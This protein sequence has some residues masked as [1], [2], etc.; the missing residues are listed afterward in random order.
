[1]KSAFFSKES[2]NHF[3]RSYV[4]LVIA[5]FFLLSGFIRP[6]NL[7]SQTTSLSFTNIP[8]NYP[9]IISPGRG[10]EQW[11]NGYGSINYPSQDLAQQ[12]LDAY[13]R[14]TWNRLE[15]SAQGSYDW[16]YFD[17]LVKEVINK[18]Q[19]LSFGIMTCYPDEG[20][21]PGMVT[22]DN[23]NSAYPEYLHQ[24]MQSEPDKDWKTTGSGPTDGYGSWVPNWNSQYYL[25]RLRALHEALYAHI[26]SSSYTATAGP[27]KGK[28]IAYSD[29]IF[30]ID[31]RGYGS[32]GE[33][34]SAGIINVMTSYPAGRRPT[35]ATLKTIIDHHV[36]VF[37][38][39]PLS[40][41]ISAFD[42]E[43]LSNTDNPKEVAAY[44]L[45][46]TNNWGKLGWRRD[47]W[48]AIDSYIDGYLKDNTLSYG[49]SGPFNAIINERWKYAPVT[50]EPPSWLASLNGACAYDDLE[51]QIREYHA[52]SFGNGNYG[53][54]D[55]ADCA[56]ENIRAAFKAAGYRIILEGG[57][58]SSTIKTGTAFALTLNWKNIGIA[59]TYEKWDVVFELK[60]SSDVSVWSGISQF[61][62][63][64]KM[65]IPALLP[66]SAAAPAVDNFTLPVNIPAG[67]YN[68][69]IIIKDPAGYRVP[70]PLAITGR[71]PD[72]SYTLKNIVVDSNTTTPTVPPTPPPAPSPLKDATLIG[73]IGL[74][75]RPA[76]PDSKWQ[77][78]LQVDL[79][80]DS[81]SSTLVNTYTVTTDSTGQFIID[82]I[83]P[84]KYNIAV[85]NSHTLKRN[86][87]DSLVTGDNRIFFGILLEGDIN[88]DNLVSSVDSILLM[89]SFSKVAGDSLFDSRAD[90]NEDGIVNTFDSLLL[91]ANYNHHGDSTGSCGAISA[92]ISN[93]PGCDGQPFDLVLSS[94]KGVSPFDV[95]VNGI[96]YN[97]IP[98]GGTI[99]TIA[100]E[101]I[102][103]V[104]PS[105]ETYEDSPVE[106][107]V[108]FSSSVAGYVKG[109]RFFS[110]NDISGTYTGH[111]WNADGT[112]LA[113]AT[114]SNVTANGWQEVSF[115]EP[116]LIDAS[117]VYTAS[118]HT[119]AGVYAA[120]SGGLTD[121]VYNGSSL[122]ALGN[123]AKG[124]NGV[125]NYGNSGFPSNT[126]NATNYWV[127]VVFTTG[128]Y[129]F[130][131]TSVTDS[132][133]CNNT[134]AL[135]TLIVTS[136]P[137]T[138]QRSVV[139]TQA[140][141]K[142]LLTEAKSQPGITFTNSLGQNYPN[143]FTNE[144]TISFS[145]A[146]PAKVNLTL[147]DMNGRL[148]KV[149]V[150][151]SR[152]AGTHTI[153]F[154]SGSL[155]KG[156]YLYKLQTGDY[157]AVKRM[158]IQ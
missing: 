84:G 81:S 46:K 27:N 95:V 145:L 30:S 58:I 147:F 61:S 3:A 66:S 85:K 86:V 4:K 52:A 91:V 116:V 19:K 51:R 92:I 18:G 108:K 149:L 49:T 31:I 124:G 106:L 134:R 74:Q 26:R 37:T 42:A 156:L 105:P 50:G 110:A 100:T 138:Q 127:D 107:G 148:V 38:D 33:W 22:Y 82:S 114:F 44:A 88:N 146:K 93:T 133:G 89:N 113:S 157:S 9:D 5:S 122:T 96:T 43:R 10:A 141:Q 75:G 136:S 11:H 68:L 103:S 118:Y 128:P 94:A 13:Y 71:N 59:P 47:N 53:S 12:S 16:E 76:A 41:M 90:L 123:T 151:G 17:G 54:T 21:N 78:P 2:P 55:L 7:F 69:N 115:T 132:T 83:S 154:N 142:P 87:S 60:N 152:E 34:H 14:F 79:Y 125:F 119:S 57:N 109:I 67:N 137:C 80:T 39:H 150:S 101:K 120:T 40:I 29:A 35:A 158:I 63:G 77:V 104:N 102:W 139:T 15:G 117:A 140:V 98:I 131:L 36:N 23:G 73:M 24:L 111:L 48:G 143:P 135:Q 64:P 20:N 155:S 112:L 56:K 32:W 97:D 45:A 28:T 8:Y 130:N 25:D 126:Y 99:T 70:L 144:T 121:A 153:R 62:P 129:S 72:G 6:V 1:M 65:L